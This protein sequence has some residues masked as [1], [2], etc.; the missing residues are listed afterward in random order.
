MHCASYPPSHRV[1]I[2]R[3]VACSLNWAVRKAQKC[4]DMQTTK[5]YSLA[6]QSAYVLTETLQR[7]SRDT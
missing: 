1:T 6:L 2:E 4:Q 5:D 3:R 7:T